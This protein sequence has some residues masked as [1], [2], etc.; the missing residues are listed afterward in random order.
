MAPAALLS[1][2]IK[3]TPK[4]GRITVTISVTDSDASVAVSDTG[5][6]IAPEFLPHMFE[7]VPR[8]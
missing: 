4:A 7:S 3:F 6:G 8:R 1:N 2:A 5:T